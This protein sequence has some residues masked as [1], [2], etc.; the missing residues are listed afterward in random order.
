[1]KFF[2]NKYQFLVKVEPTDD[3]KYC[4]YPKERIHTRKIRGSGYIYFQY[5]KTVKRIRYDNSLW[6]TEVLENDEIETEIIN[7]K[8]EWPN[9]YSIEVYPIDNELNNN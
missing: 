6:F 3:N 5:N 9:W 2:I 1:M 4:M 7:I 8:N